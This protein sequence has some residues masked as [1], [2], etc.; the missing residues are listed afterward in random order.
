MASKPQ[1]STKAWY[2][3][4]IFLGIIGGAIQFIVLRKEEPRKAKRGLYVGTGITIAGFF[5]WIP[6]Y[7]IGLAI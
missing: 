7:A 5:I 6:F 4:P 3:L 2:L 1:N